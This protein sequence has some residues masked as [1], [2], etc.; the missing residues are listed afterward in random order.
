MAVRSWQLTEAVVAGWQNVAA[1]LYNPDEKTT[2]LAQNYTPATVPMAFYEVT[3]IDGEG[4]WLLATVESDL[5]PSQWLNFGGT[6][7]LQAS[8]DEIPTSINGQPVLR[9]KVLFWW[10][11]VA[12]LA[13]VT[14]VPEILEGDIIGSVPI[15]PP[16]DTPVN[17]EIEVIRTDN[18][19][20]LVVPPTDT[21]TTIQVSMGTS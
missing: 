15:I 11:P 21:D 17:P 8:G 20:I 6:E 4:S 13:L 16:S 10:V 2:A 3:A 19:V 18:G 14:V 7:A 1:Y 9:P 12:T 5:A